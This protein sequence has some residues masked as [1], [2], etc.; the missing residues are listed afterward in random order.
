[1]APFNYAFACL[2]TSV[3]LFFLSLESIKL[4]TQNLLMQSTAKQKLHSHLFIMQSFPRKKRQQK[5]IEVWKE[6]KELQR[7]MDDDERA[8]S[9]EQ[10][11]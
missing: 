4:A 8:R 1:L 7:T 2:Q 6:G 10:A 9:T 11:T 3:G 5:T